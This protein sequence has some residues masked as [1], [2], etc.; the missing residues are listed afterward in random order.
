MFPLKENIIIALNI[1][2][3]A[4]NITVTSALLWLWLPK[5]FDAEIA[6]HLIL[7]LSHVNS[8]DSRAS[9]A[10]VRPTEKGSPTLLLS[11]SFGKS[12]FSGIHIV[13]ILRIRRRQKEIE[14]R[15]DLHNT[16]KLRK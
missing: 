3:S 16:R 2:Q 13:G 6:E 1:K 7:V 14:E 5:T 9:R 11:F 8:R 12:V 4:K 15:K 10:K